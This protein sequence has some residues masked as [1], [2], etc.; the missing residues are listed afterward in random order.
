MTEKERYLIEEED[1]LIK[2]QNLNQGIYPVGTVVADPYEDR[3]IYLD[4]K[5]REEMANNKILENSQFN[6]VTKDIRNINP[7]VLD[8]T[9]GFKPP[10]TSVSTPPIGTSTTGIMGGAGTDMGESGT[11]PEAISAE[12]WY[13]KKWLKIAGISLGGLLIVALILFFALKNRG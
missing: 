12:K 2:Y 6:I 3:R 11:P 10:P 4:Q 13:Q 8:G 7:I 9:G 1:T 5:I